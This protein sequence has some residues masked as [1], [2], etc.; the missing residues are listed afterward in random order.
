MDEVP[1]LA[2]VLVH[3]G[4]LTAGQRGAEEGGDTGV[5]G[6]AWHPRPVDVVVAQR[7]GPAAGRAGPR[8]G[9]MF[10][11]EFGRGI[12]IAGVDGRVLADQARPQGCR[13]DRTARLEPARVQIGH[14]PRPGTHHPVFGTGVAALPVDHH[15]PGEHQRPD[16]GLGHL[17]QQH[18]RAQ[19][20]AADV[21]GRIREVLAQAHHRRLVAH[22]VHPVQ[23]PGDRRP[24][25]YVRDDPPLAR[26]RRRRL[27]MGGRQQRI[28]DDHF[29]SPRLQ[30][31]D[32]L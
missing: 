21:G 18:G 5:R 1:P 4:G 3:R 12:H 11:G 19:V 31:G 8:G 26:P 30:H 32:D 9:E 14:R 2:A 15:R 24:V 23:R 10:L 20:V 25:P 17:R 13:A 6:V 22:R 29:M 27:W 7:D 16:P 28:E